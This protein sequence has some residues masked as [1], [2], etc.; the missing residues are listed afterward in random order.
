MNDRI[1]KYY[2]TS[3]YSIFD[4]VVRGKRCPKEKKNGAKSG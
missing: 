4:V 3:H 2:I 1:Y